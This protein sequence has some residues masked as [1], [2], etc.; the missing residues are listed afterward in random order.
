MSTGVD[1]FMF[2]ALLSNV[3]AAQLASVE[4]AAAA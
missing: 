2:D 4:Q 1:G 3:K